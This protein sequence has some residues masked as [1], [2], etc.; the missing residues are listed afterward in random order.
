MDRQENSIKMSAHEKLRVQLIRCGQKLGSGH[1]KK[2]TQGRIL[3]ILYLY[4]PMSQRILQEK[5]DIQPGS[6]SEIAAKL[7]HKGLLFRQ[8]DPADKR[9]ILLTLTEA[10]RTDVEQFRK[11][12]RS[13]HTA[14]FDALTPEEQQQLSDL[15]EK[16]LAS[17]SAASDK[18][19]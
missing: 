6:M 8:K 4:G 7:E 3:K 15:L 2:Q 5:L 16:L 11:C 9:Q 14:D 19:R 18:N 1:G 10:G 12:G 13:Q 17:W